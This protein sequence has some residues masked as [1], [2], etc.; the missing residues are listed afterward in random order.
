[1]HRNEVIAIVN[2]VQRLGTIGIPDI[3]ITAYINEQFK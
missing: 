1:M 2:E 3:E